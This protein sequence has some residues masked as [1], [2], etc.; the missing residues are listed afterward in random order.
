[1]K[2][3]LIII[4]VLFHYSCFSAYKYYVSTSGSDSYAGTLANPF[5][6]IQK[7]LD[8]ARAGDTVFVRAGTYSNY[9][10][11]GYSGTIGS[12][13]V[14]KNYQAETVS[15]DG[16][17][18]RS[19]CL[20]ATNKGYIVIDG[21]NVQNSANYNILIEG[22]NNIVLKNI[23]STLGLSSAAINV[24]IAFS[25]T[26]WCTNITVQ[27]I[28]T[29]GGQIG[30]WLR[31]KL[32]GISVIRGNFS[33]SVLDGINVVGETVADSTNFARNFVI[34]GSESH[35]NSRQGIITWCVKN[36]TF[37][38]FWSHHNS[39]TGLQVENE[40]HNVIVQDFLCEDNSQ[41]DV[42]ETG[43]WIDD[44]DSVIVRRG[45]MRNNQTGFRVS[46]SQKVWVYNNL[47]YSNQDGLST[48]MINTSGINFYYNPPTDTYPSLYMCNVHFYNNTV[49]NNSDAT[50]QR[51]CVV[52]QGGGVYTL[53]NNIFSN[54]NSARD[55]Y[56]SGNY[57][58]VSDY[59]LWYNTRALSFYN[60]TSTVSYSAYKTATG[61]ELHSINLN[62]LYNSDLSIQS[63]SPAINAGS[64]VGVAT[65]F[66]SNTRTENPDI[67]A[68]EYTSSVPPI[69]TSKSKIISKNKRY[70]S[71]KG[72]PIKR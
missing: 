25:T 53:K 70:L 42:F 58:L 7:G 21:I 32:N 14:L 46:G 36:I 20:Y 52:L 65:D 62:P 3:I 47:I 63:T 11:F 29:Y 72:K 43:L 27:D 57:T 15:I 31:Y 45:I 4:L 39:A 71:Y 13:I 5:A 55:F 56:G 23:S 64:D 12:P 68:Y 37:K 1:M 22:C 8:V 61:Q 66:L 54:D 41:G 50:S 59:N 49:D 2:K 44:S 24:D 6:T 26:N 38:N 10:Q 18:S 48:G 69:S 19:Y 60:Q 35:H 30:L 16:G 51:G 9:V 34:D 40:S 17:S 28:N 67:G 33:Y